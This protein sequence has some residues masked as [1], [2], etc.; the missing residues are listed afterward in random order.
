MTMAQ[1]KSMGL[2][3]AKRHIDTYIESRRKMGAWVESP[4]ETPEDMYRSW[5]KFVRLSQEV[6]Q[7]GQP[8][9]DD[10]DRIAGILGQGI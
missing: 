7:T 3:V 10:F 2:G 8:S 4:F 6:A 9:R 1:A 5:L